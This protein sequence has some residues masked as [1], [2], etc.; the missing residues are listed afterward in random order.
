MI[1]QL[2]FITAAAMI[3]YRLCDRNDWKGSVADKVRNEK[4]SRMYP[5]Y[6]SDI[7]NPFQHNLDLIDENFR[8]G[9]GDIY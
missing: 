2:L 5:G 6:T 3:F 7:S 4:P 9:N 8:F 1:I